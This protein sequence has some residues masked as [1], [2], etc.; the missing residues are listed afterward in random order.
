MG[1]VAAPS[2]G[3]TVAVRY[4]TP[5]RQHPTCAFSGAVC[6]ASLCSLDNTVATGIKDEAAVPAGHIVIEHPSGTIA[7]SIETRPNGDHI[8]VVKAGAVRT[9]RL[10]MRGEVLVLP[11][12][13]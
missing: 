11:R 13:L 2:Q 9:A 10:I 3:G 7:V 4:F 6:A 8:G 1:L 5:T 12:P